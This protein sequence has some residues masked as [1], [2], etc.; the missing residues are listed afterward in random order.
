MWF[1]ILQLVEANLLRRLQPTSL[2]Q[3]LTPLKCSIMMIAMTLLNIVCPDPE[4]AGKAIVIV[5][6]VALEDQFGDAMERLGIRYLSLTSTFVETLEDQIQELQPLVLLTNVE[7]LNDSGIQR[8]ISKL[9]LSYI[10]IDKD[11][12]FCQ[13]MTAA[14]SLSIFTQPTS[15]NGPTIHILTASWAMEKA[16]SYDIASFKASHV[17][18]LSGDNTHE[19]KERV[20]LG[21]RTG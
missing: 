17:E 16:K 18:K 8:K 12:V 1:R 4:E 15:P 10:A 21:L 11:K 19:E 14:E 6:L 7:S 20:M 2:L 5:P 9:K 13:S 3:V